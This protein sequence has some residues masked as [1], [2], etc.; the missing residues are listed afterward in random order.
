MTLQMM[1]FLCNELQLESML[2]GEEVQRDFFD[3]FCLS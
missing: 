2:D 3:Y 1:T